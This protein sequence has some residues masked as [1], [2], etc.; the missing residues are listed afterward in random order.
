VVERQAMEGAL[1]RHTP[2]SGY[3]L[4]WVTLVA[5]EKPNSKYI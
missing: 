2:A 5:F 3:L 4:F 1:P